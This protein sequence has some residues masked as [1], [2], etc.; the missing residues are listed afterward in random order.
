MTN[1]SYT[2]SIDMRAGRMICFQYGG[3][4]LQ[5]LRLVRAS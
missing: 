3:L 4:H 1:T 2:P 5:N